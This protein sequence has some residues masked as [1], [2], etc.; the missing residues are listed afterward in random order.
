LAEYITILSIVREI[1]ECWPHE[2]D[3]CRSLSVLAFYKGAQVPDWVLARVIDAAT[4]G[5]I[6]TAG[7]RLYLIPTGSFE[8][9]SREAVNRAKYPKNR[10]KKFSPHIRKRDCIPLSNYLPKKRDKGKATKRQNP[11]SNPHEQRAVEAV[12]VTPVHRHGSEHK[13]NGSCLSCDAKLVGKRRGAKYCDRA[14]KQRAFRSG[15]SV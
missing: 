1:V 2:A 11:I 5:F 7:M 3:R 4:R 10:K 15:V 12:C 14:C 6:T 9:A 8:R 13:G